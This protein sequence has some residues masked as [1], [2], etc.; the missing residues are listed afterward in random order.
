M[1]YLYRADPAQH[2][3]TADWDLDDLDD[4]DRGLS[5]VSNFRYDIPDT[6]ILS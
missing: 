2:L 5:D 1:L 3:T 4:L 6:L